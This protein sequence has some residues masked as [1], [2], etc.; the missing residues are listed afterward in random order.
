MRRFIVLFLLLSLYSR[1][2]SLF[3]EGDILVREKTDPESNLE[4]AGGV[5]LADPSKLWASGYVYYRYSFNK[6]DKHCQ[7]S[8]GSTGPFKTLNIRGMWKT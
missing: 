3:I 2:Y 4:T 1:S 6:V 5:I 7:Q 8:L